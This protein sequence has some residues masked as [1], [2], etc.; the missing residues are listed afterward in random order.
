M[1]AELHRPWW[2]KYL[3]TFLV[4]VAATILLAALVAYARPLP[5][6]HAQVSLSPGV[7]T[8]NGMWSTTLTV[9]EDVPDGTAHISD[10]ASPF[11]HSV[12]FTRTYNLRSNV[13]P[14]TVTVYVTWP[15]GFVSDTFHLTAHVPE[16]GC[17]EA[18]TTTTTVRQAT[19]QPGEHL[20]NPSTQ[21]NVCVPD[22]TVPSEP[23]TVVTNP[24]TSVVAPPETSP[25]VSSP[26]T[27]AA[28]QSPTTTV[29]LPTHL[30]VTGAASTDTLVAGVLAVI[31]G[32]GLIILGRRRAS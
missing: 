17:V 27:T 15:D 12:P 7:C 29:A 5:Q 26:P 1:Q 9:T 24:P 16:G 30:P 22:I 18:P 19:C 8:T 31:I 13:S 2:P 4:L 11:T 28:P 6:H 23:T 25:P 10:P 20:R 14:W 32:G 3:A 21:D